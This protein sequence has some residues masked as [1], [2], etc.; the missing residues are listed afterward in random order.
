MH[1]TITERD[2]VPNI[3]P[4]DLV[5]HDHG[6]AVGIVFKQQSELRIAWSDGGTTTAVYENTTKF[7]GT[8]STQ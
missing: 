5:I 3:V 8:I 2:D 4:G 6:N 7:S 1:L